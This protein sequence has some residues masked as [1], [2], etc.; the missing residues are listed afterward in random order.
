[1][2]PKTKF[3]KKPSI[4]PSETAN[5]SLCLNFP[6]IIFVALNIF[7]AMFAVSMLLLNFAIRKKFEE[8]QV[9][10]SSQYEPYIGF[11]AILS[12]VVIVVN[13]FGCS[14][15][16]L[17]S[18]KCL[19]VYLVITA[20]L[21]ITQ[22]TFVA[23]LMRFQGNFSKIVIKNY[24]ELESYQWKLYPL[25]RELN[26][27]NFNCDEAVGKFINDKIGEMI[28]ACLGMLV[29]QVKKLIITFKI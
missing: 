21:F 16:D 3:L 18:R 12:F 29:C 22:L 28:Y 6:R 8:F 24:Q 7:A 23:Y 14:C 13:I 9:V 25:Q 26:C 2:I 27:F 1:M 20:V 19:I 11:M 17:K 15:A 4:S 5:S 10:I